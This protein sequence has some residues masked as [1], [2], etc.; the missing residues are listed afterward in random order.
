MLKAQKILT[1]GCEGF[2][3]YVVADN[4]SEVSLGDIR[5]IRE[6]LDIFPEDLHELPPD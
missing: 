1:K 4:S 5:E 2:L 3:A 6:S